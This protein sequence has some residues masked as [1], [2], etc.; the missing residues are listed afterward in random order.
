[1]KTSKKN[2]KAGGFAA[3]ERKQKINEWIEPIHE[4][5]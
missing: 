1:M 3:S 2:W 4:L 5:H